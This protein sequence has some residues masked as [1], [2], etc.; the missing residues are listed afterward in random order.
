M[1][2]T[3][4]R[5]LLQGYKICDFTRVLS[6]P[7]CTRLLS[8]LGADVYKIEKPG[9]GDEIRYIIPQMNDEAADQ[10][11]YFARVNAGKK[12]IA[13]DFTRPEALDIVKDL[14]LQCDVVVENFSPGVMAKYK[15]DYASLKAIKPDLVYCSIS[16]FGQTGPLRQT[17]A[18]AHLI[19]A[20]SGM[21]ELERAGLHPPRVSNLQAAD[22]LAGAHAFGLVCAALLRKAKS[23]EGAYLDVSMLECLICADDVSYA[24]LL[25][26]HEATRQPRPSM[27][28]HPV[29]GKHIAMQIG[30]ALGMWEKLIRLMN[31]PDL[32]ADERF[33]TGPARRQ[34]WPQVLEIIYAWLDTFDS[35]DE[36][37]A[38]LSAERFPAVPMLQ[39]EDIVKHPHLQLRKA[40]PVIQHPARPQGVTV[41]ASPFH[42]D[43]APLAPP[44]NAP[45]TIG[46]DTMDILREVLHYPEQRIQSLQEKGLLPA[47]SGHN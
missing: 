27:V 2:T 35:V 15:L 32:S 38:L 11:A 33:L 7:Y 9:E 39:P 21:M 31:R 30:G 25:N 42:V 24:A 19:N 41:T 17:Q 47:L 28:I 36:V 40:F 13:L 44:V 3:H 12:S 29:G 26:G 4:T 14:V 45:W 23:G 22:V 8:D 43:G 1:S 34:N 37:M 18:Y 5:Q 16:G 10:S 20:F 46:Q 6:G